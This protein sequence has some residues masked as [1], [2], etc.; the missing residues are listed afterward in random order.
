MQKFSRR[1]LNTIYSRLCKLLNE[2]S[3]TVSDCP[4]GYDQNALVDSLWNLYPP[5]IRE[6]KEVLVS[7]GI[8]IFDKLPRVWFSINGCL[9]K[10]DLN[11][12]A[13]VPHTRNDA[14]VIGDD[15]NVYHEM[16]Q[17]TTEMMAFE[18]RSY[19]ARK[20]IREVVDEGRCSTAG[21]LKR[22]WPESVNFI[23]DYYAGLLQEAQRKSRIPY[24]IVV[25]AEF[26]GRRR[27]TNETLALCKL[28][29]A[30]A[31]TDRSVKYSVERA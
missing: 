26:N 8:K 16:I 1:D 19:I 18:E 27:I 6:A 11:S 5:D 10:V 3:H 30:H 15:S 13:V 9:I 17:W 14:I 7:S 4:L 24:D 21:Q 12:Y 25:D 2:G 23:G 22:V 20:F 28:T 31:S 29:I